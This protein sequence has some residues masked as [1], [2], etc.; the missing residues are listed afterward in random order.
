MNDGARA[1][2]ALGRA[3]SGDAEAL[4]AETAAGRQVAEAGLAPDLV[5]CAQTDLR[6]VVPVLHDRSITLSE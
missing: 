2:L 5:F 3:W 6:D 4:F 1:A